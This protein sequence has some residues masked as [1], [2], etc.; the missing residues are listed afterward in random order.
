MIPR[1]SPPTT[2]TSTGWISARPRN[3]RRKFLGVDLSRMA[4]DASQKRVPC[5][6]FLQR[7]LVI[8]PQ[9]WQI[10]DFKA[11]HALCS[12]V[13]EHLDEPAMLLHHALAYMG[14]DC[15]LV[16]TVPGGARNKFDEYI[17]HRRHYTAQELRQLLERAGFAV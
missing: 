11:T 2:G 5:A 1:P 4:V 12:E 10:V 3:P 6:Q 8:S 9:P 16:V 13:L 7:D 17:G 15:K 14:P